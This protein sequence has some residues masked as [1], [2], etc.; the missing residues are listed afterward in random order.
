MRCQPVIRRTGVTASVMRSNRSVQIPVVSVMSSMGFALSR[1]V[2]LRNS[3]H[4]NGASAARMRRWGWREV[5]VHERHARLDGE[6]RDVLVAER[7]L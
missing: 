5:G 1:P 2:A 7:L 3:S 4:R 6:W